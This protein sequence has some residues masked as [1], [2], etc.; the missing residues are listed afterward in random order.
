MLLVCKEMDLL[1]RARPSIQPRVWRV[2]DL[3][4]RRSWPITIL[5][6]TEQFRSIKIG[7][8]TLADG[9]G[10]IAGRAPTGQAVVQFFA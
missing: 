4:W 5:P 1:A 10:T 6:L 3:H 9:L 7:A 8:M 2:K